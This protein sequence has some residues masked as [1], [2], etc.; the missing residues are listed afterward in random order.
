MLPCFGHLGA[1][2]YH[3]SYAVRDL[4]EAMAAVGA[5]FELEWGEMTSGVMPGLGP[6]DT[7]GWDTRRVLSLG[8]PVHTELSEGSGGSIWH[9]EQLAVFHHFAYWCEDLAGTLAEMETD[10]WTL[11]LTLLESGAPREFAYITKPGWP[12]LELVDVKRAQSF[13]DANRHIGAAASIGAN[14]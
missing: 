7:D 10:G 6:V 8:G 14:R 5:L 1:V 13:V 4:D 12:R 9:T 11:E 3:V 2:P